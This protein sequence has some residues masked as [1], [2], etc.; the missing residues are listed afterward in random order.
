MEKEAEI[1]GRKKN[2]KKLQ[3]SYS[4]NDEEELS[5]QD[6]MDFSPVYRCMHIYNVLG[7]G[8]TF[9]TYYRQQRQH[10]AKLVLQPPLN[11]VRCNIK[12]KCF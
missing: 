10:Q 4:L 1:T 2:Q 11:M 5:A 9:K 6:L 7:E 3:K 12:K 8:E